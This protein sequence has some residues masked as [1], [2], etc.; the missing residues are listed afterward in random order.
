[1]N[2]TPDDLPNDSTLERELETIVAVDP[3]PEFLARV[4]TRIA[5]EPAPSSWRWSL[6]RRS[7]GEGGWGFALAG[8]AAAMV[9]AVVLASWTAIFTPIDA[10]QQAVSSEDVTLE[11]APALVRLKPDTTGEMKAPDTTR[12]PVVRRG[13]LQA[14]RNLQPDRREASDAPP[15]AEVLISEAER[16]AFEN[17]LRAVQQDRLPVI[18]RAEDEVNEPLVPAP[19]E[20]EQLTIE[21]LQVTRLE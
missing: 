12:E 17:L 20:I 16:R 2:H 18:V 7:L 3:S 4:R 8:A 19:L 6:G 15:F 10:P 21:P 1:M 11:P 5:Q 13:R 9:L 14:A